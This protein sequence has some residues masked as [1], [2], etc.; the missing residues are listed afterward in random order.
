MLPDEGI[1]KVTFFLVLT[2][3]QLEGTLYLCFLD[4]K[5]YCCVPFELVT[6]KF[7]VPSQKFHL[8]RPLKSEFR[9]M[10]WEELAQPLAQN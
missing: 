3:V 8:E 6:C 2:S 7:K 10:N 5:E 1:Q 4:E 9:L